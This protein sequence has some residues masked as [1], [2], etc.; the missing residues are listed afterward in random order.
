MVDLAT[1]ALATIGVQLSR[2]DPVE[3]ISLAAR[4]GAEA[5]LSLKVRERLGAAL[6]QG[7]HRGWAKDVCI[8]GVAPRRWLI[9]RD[10]ADPDFE[11]NLAADLS[12]LAAVCLQSDA[13]VVLRVSGPGARAALAK[14]VPIDLHPKVFSTA[15]AAVTTAAHVNVILWQVEERPTY[16]LAVYRSYARHFRG[17]LR[18]SAAEFGLEDLS[19]GER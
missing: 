2:R 16:E 4:R 9:V 5:A 6:P 8:L 11:R 13:Y 14:G 7:P 1:P 15:D 10:G 18:D 19:Q 3:I 17:W 12:G